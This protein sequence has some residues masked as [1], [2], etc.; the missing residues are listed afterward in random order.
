[1]GTRTTRARYI[2]IIDEE[3]L[4][5][6]SSLGFEAQEPAAFTRQRGDVVH[7]VF[8]APDPSYTRFHVPVGAVVP[9]INERLDYVRGGKALGL[10]V[11]RWLGEFKPN[12]TRDDYYYHFATVEQMRAQIPKMYSDFLEQAEPWLADMTS[13]EGVAKEFYKLRIGP[14][15]SGETRPPDPYAWAQYGWLLQESGKPKKVVLGYNALS[16]SF[17]CQLTCKPDDWSYTAC[18]ATNPFP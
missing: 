7:G 12:F 8:F 16:I 13:V 9:V 2:Q 6:F 10:I 3:V 5:L 11:S 15:P 18:P 17:N 1:M 4:P 14:A